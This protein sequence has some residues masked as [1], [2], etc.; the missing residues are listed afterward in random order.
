MATSPTQRARS[1]IEP[2]TMAAIPAARPSSPSITL[3]HTVIVTIQ[4]T[5]S[6]HA[7]QPV[8]STNHVLTEMERI[9]APEAQIAIEAAIRHN[10]LM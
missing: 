2:H 4:N 7:A 9:V 5:V 10:S 6:G 1:T 8:S 3:K